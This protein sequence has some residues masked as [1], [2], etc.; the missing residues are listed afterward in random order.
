MAAV[1]ALP[2]HIF[3]PRAFLKRFYN[4]TQGLAMASPYVKLIL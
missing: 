3:V 2:V 4:L 1:A